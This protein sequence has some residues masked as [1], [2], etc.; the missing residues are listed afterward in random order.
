MG[1]GKLVRLAQALAAPLERLLGDHGTPV[2]LHSG[3]IVSAQQLS[4]DH[5]F[6]F[7]SRRD[8]D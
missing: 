6:E 8:T 4:R 3:G 1:A 2:A 7:V 5:P